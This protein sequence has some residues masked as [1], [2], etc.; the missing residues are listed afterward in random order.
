M[1]TTDD[2]FVAHLNNGSVEVHIRDINS[3]YQEFFN[4]ALPEPPIS[5]A[6]DE[7]NNLMAAGGRVDNSIAE[8]RVYD[9]ANDFNFINTLIANDDISS[10]DFDQENNFLAYAGQDCNVIDIDNN[11]NSVAVLSDASGIN[12]VDFNEKDGFLAVGDNN[13]DTFIYDVNNNF[14][15]IKTVT[16]SNISNTESVSFNQT[17]GLLAC[18]E[19][20]DNTFIFDVDNNFSLIKT[21][22]DPDGCASIAFDESNGYMAVGSNDSSLYVYDVDNSF[23]LITTL[24]D[25]KAGINGVDFNESV[26]LLASNCDA[27]FDKLEYKNGGNVN[28][29]DYPTGPILGSIFQSSS[30]GVKQTNSSGVVLTQ[31]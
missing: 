9:V 29:Y 17:E 26:G 28:V 14:T 31:A 24:T 6:F 25:A 16:T 4:P 21:L 1:T 8:G 27:N 7:T 22:S 5:V 13:G 23:S 20:F 19:P 12:S 11:F 30:S 18:G 10:L 2:G 3:S 15:L